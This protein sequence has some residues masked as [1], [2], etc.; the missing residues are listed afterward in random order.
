MHIYV[1]THIYIHKHTY[2]CIH[3]GF[4]VLGVLWIVVSFVVRI[5]TIVAI[6][7][8]DDDTIIK[9]SDNVT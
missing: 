1:H 7:I 6:E 9:W 3:R 8:F 4:F 2:T 5:L